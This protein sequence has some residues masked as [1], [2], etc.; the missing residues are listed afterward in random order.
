MGQFVKKPVP[1]GSQPLDSK[2]GDGQVVFPW[3][4]FGIRIRAATKIPHTVSQVSCA[5][6]I[7][8]IVIL[9]L[10]VHVQ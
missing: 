3:R 6:N 5:L 4:F 10:S 1:P 8:T 2:L 9:T 7:D